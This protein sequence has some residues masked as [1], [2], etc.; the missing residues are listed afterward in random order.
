M[1]GTGFESLWIRSMAEVR[2]RLECAVWS[3][4]KDYDI[5]VI[6]VAFDFIVSSL[7]KLDILWIVNEANSAIE[8]FTMEL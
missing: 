8:I 4:N 3:S 6:W 2:I 5:F 1:A 7:W